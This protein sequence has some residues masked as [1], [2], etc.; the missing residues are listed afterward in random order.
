MQGLSL[1]R[2]VGGGPLVASPE[3]PAMAVFPVQSGVVPPNASES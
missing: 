2:A 1:P 3:T